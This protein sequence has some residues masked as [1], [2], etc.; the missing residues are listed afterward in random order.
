MS[1]CQCEGHKVERFVSVLL[2]FEV[3]SEIVRA[4][5]WVEWKETVMGCDMCEW[6][7]DV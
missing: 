3:G 1:V 4:G 6:D 2:F 7:S 5:V